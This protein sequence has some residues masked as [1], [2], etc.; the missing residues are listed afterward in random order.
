MGGGGKG[1][2]GAPSQIT[3]GPSA[4]AERLGNIQGDIANSLFGQSARTRA[5]VEANTFGELFNRFG[6]ES[7]R[8]LEFSPLDTNLDFNPLDP[9]RVE[10]ITANPS[11]AAQKAFADQQF[12]T[13]RESALA[14]A[15]RGGVLNELLGDLNVAEARDQTSR[16]GI[17]A[18]QE[19][20]RRERERAGGLDVAAGNL[21]RAANE[22][23]GA[24]TVAEQNRSVFEREK[25]RRTQQG[26]LIATGQTGQALSGLSSAGGNLAALGANQASIANAQANRDAGKSSGLGQAVGSIGKAAILA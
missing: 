13:A 17:L 26:N 8:P 12:S 16:F 18:D 24:L 7:L 14:N 25:D 3:T 23:A 5:Q 4:A 19:V 22:R 11:F 21:A 1:G 6:T 15:P 9:V 10:D 2:G 20:A